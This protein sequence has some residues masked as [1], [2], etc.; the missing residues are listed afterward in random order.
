MQDYLRELTDATR[1][2][3]EVKQEYESEI[4]DST[5]SLRTVRGKIASQEQ[6]QKLTRA[7]MK[8]QEMEDRDWDAAK[9]QIQVDQEQ[10]QTKNRDL[11]GIKEDITKIT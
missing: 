3:P 7:C 1:V 5:R 10:L 9:T 4:Q 11:E 2:W 8:T 6:I